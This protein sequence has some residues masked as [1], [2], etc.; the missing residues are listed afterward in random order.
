MFATSL[1]SFM[2]LGLNFHCIKPKYNGFS[3]LANQNL[4]KKLS[5]GLWP[6]ASKYKEALKLPDDRKGIPWLLLGYQRVGLSIA[7][8]QKI[9]TLPDENS[10]NELP[11]AICMEQEKEKEKLIFKMISIFIRYYGM[12]FTSY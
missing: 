7:D 10:G 1:S 3:I 11:K 9:S 8:S 12:G 6:F 5:Y 2:S 4:Q